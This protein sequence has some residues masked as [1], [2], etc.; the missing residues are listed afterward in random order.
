MKEKPTGIGEGQLIR[1]LPDGQLQYAH[2]ELTIEAP[3]EIRIGDRTVAT[4]MR[5]PG[6]DEELAAGF[7]LAEDVI[8]RADDVAGFQRGASGNGSLSVQL[9]PGLIFKPEAGARLG[10]ISSSCGLCGKPDLAGVIANVQPLAFN[11]GPRVTMETLLQLPAKLRA[12]QSDFERTGGLHAAGLFTFDGETRVVREDIGRHNAADKAIGRALLDGMI[13]LA[14]HILMVSGRLSFEIMQKALAARVPVV[15]S[16][17]APST[18]AVE[19]ARASG[20]CVIGFLRP[21]TC[22]LYTHTEWIVLD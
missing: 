2:D 17:S 19:F 7:F 18:L 1:R 11:A 20:Q 8:E 4:T 14:R 3:L 15:A 12:A 16:V 5:T 10:T 22:N 9:R 21:P 13:P 6:H